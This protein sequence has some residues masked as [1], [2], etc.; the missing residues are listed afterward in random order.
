MAE[1]HH[2]EWSLEDV[3]RVRDELRLQAH[4]LEAEAKEEWH[5]LEHKWEQITKNLGPAAQ[6][7]AEDIGAASDLLLDE[8]EKGYKRIRHVLT[9]S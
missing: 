2:R 6:K 7:S 5:E 1:S 9:K 4:L 8:L 3:N